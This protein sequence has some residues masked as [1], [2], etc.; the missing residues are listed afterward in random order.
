MTRGPT[1][2]LLLLAIVAAGLAALLLLDDDN[3][4]GAVNP[5]ASAPRNAETTDASQVDP[6]IPYGEIETDTF[7][8][9]D[10]IGPAPA[11]L[12]D[13]PRRVR[14]LGLDGEPVAGVTVQLVREGQARE[15]R[16]RAFDRSTPS[17]PYRTMRTDSEGRAPLQPLP[18]RAFRIEA[19]TDDAFGS[20]GFSIPRKNPESAPLVV[21]LH[22]LPSPGVRIRVLQID[23]TPAEAMRVEVHPDPSVRHSWDERLAVWTDGEGYAGGRLTFE[24]KW[25]R[26]GAPAL[27]TVRLLDGSRVTT[28][29]VSP[30]DG[31][32]DF[33]LTGPRLG[34]VRLAFA[35]PNGKLYKGTASLKWWRI[36]D[37]VDAR[38]SGR[39]TAHQGVAVIGGAPPGERLVLRIRTKNRADA[40]C[41]I[42]VHPNGAPQDAVCSI[43]AQAARLSMTFTT[44]EGD[45]LPWHRFRAKISQDD[46]AARAERLAVLDPT[47]RRGRTS[48]IRAQAD[49]RATLTVRAG[50][51]GQVLLFRDRDDSKRRNGRRKATPEATLNFPAL[52][53]NA[54]HDVGAVPIRSFRLIVSGIVV[55]T[56]GE[57][58]PAARIRVD[59]ESIPKRRS[60]RTKRSTIAKGWTNS[61]GRFSI[62][63]VPPEPGKLLIYASARYGSGSAEP[64]VFELGARDVRLVLNR[65]GE[66]MGRVTL[67][68]AS[69]PLPVDVRL[70]REDG[71]RPV[72]VEIKRDKNGKVHGDDLTPGVYGV[73]VRVGGLRELDLHGIRVGEGETVVPPALADLIVGQTFRPG[74]VFVRNQD[75]TPVWKAR[76]STRERSERRA[77]N[78]TLDTDK[79]GEAVLVWRP[80]V[81]IDL[82]V[83]IPEWRGRYRNPSFPLV[84][85]I[86]DQ[87]SASAGSPTSTTVSPLIVTFDAPLPRAKPITKYMLRLTKMSEASKRQ[88]LERTTIR[89]RP[90]RAVYV[91][92]A[93]GTYS[94]SLEV[95]LAPAKRNGRSRSGRADMGSL[96]ILGTGGERAQISVDFASIDHAVRN[97]R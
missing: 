2:P 78:Q 20:V 76:V 13:G 22:L 14:V 23:G 92:I 48:T 85:T 86:G 81:P 63:G 12:R 29:P 45:P 71:P 61:E 80:G 50:A 10:E 9:G 33:D 84:V 17:P 89:T 43:G 47:Q 97:A 8:E 46:D 56:D 40:L 15:R 28:P 25:A 44:A 21:D 60:S 7:D 82:S 65:H 36:T 16:R 58:V 30:I 5:P 53:E 34:M 73:S 57:V 88:I 70:T 66:I 1:I 6:P 51:A 26:D 38:R 83:R 59:R 3:G 93:G 87:A 96:T 4:E 95:H 24:N 64:V 74:R 72:R 41:A 35:L 37:P 19:I 77:R 54:E 79:Q 27:A 49:G 32:Y 75:G 52:E 11:S 67:N 39:S 94:V 62:P 18:A 90:D 69:M 55:D 31:L 68:D 91:D 42:D